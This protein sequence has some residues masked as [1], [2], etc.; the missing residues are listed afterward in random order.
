[1]IVTLSAVGISISIVE[2]RIPSLFDLLFMGA[3]KPHNSANLI[4]R[5][6]AAVLQAHRIKP[7]LGDFVISFDMDVGRFIPI[8][9]EK[10]KAVRSNS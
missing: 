6:A 3:D 10:E 2:V 9:R 5:E 4:S 8:T 1:M 7:K